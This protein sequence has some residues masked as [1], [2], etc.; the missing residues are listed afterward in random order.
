MRNLINFR[1]IIYCEFS[2]T[3]NCHFR[4]SVVVKS[5][6][7]SRVVLLLY[8]A[9]SFEMIDLKPVLSFSFRKLFY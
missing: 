4:K 6:Q 5:H 1:K 2:K 7:I 9:R 8:A 3:Q